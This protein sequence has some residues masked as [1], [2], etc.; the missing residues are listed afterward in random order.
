MMGIVGR[1]CQTPYGRRFQK[2]PTNLDIMACAV[3]SAEKIGAQ[4]SC[5]WGNRASRLV[6]SFSSA[7][8]MPAGPTAKVAVLKF[9]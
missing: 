5:L 7:G 4:A 2:R 8:K 6:K 9:T 1:L 3:L